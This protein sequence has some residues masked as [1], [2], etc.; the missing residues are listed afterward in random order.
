M[1][2]LTGKHVL[3]TRAP[4]QA[5][6]L[7]DLLQ[8]AGAIPVL[9]PCIEIHPPQ[10]NEALDQALIQL[11]A[12]QFQWLIVTSA[13]TAYSLAE[14]LKTLKITLP[15]AQKI[16][17]AAVGP[18]TADAVKKHLNLNVEVVPPT[19]TASALAQAMALRPGTPVLLPQSEIAD[20]TL[21]SALNTMQADLTSVTAY[22]N[23]LGRG[24]IHLLDYLQQPMLQA[25]TFTSSSTVTNFIQR[26]QNEGG[27]IRPLQQVCIACI[28]P[29]T[30]AT[31]QSNGLHVNI[32]PTT[33]T[34]E[35]L[36]DA[37]QEYF[38]KQKAST[39]DYK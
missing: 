39:Y 16:Q 18:S 10:D 32:V 9:Y 13:N 36:V 15:H 6:E 26:L 28:G 37:L 20:D 38:M 17:V 22:Q 19:Y 8:R 21:I 14:R 11:A 5:A 25:I 29:K 33:H 24:G 35:A 12:G 23:S 34:L 2:A 7:A 27:D 31:A 1:S 4:H 30:A 3:I